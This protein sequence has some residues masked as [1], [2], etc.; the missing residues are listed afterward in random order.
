M[1]LYKRMTSGLITDFSP[2]KTDEKKHFQRK[3]VNVQFH[4]QKQFHNLSF[5]SHSKIKILQT[6]KDKRHLQIFTE[7]SKKESEPTGK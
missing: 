1:E 6:Y 2:I 3:T 5:K 7:S 4:T